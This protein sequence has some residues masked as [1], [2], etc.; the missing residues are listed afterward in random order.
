[1]SKDKRP[2]ADI[3]I[4][5]D[6]KSNPVLDFYTDYP[7]LTRMDWLVKIYKELDQDFIYAS[8]QKS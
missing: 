8:S 1:M 2:L 4:D 7:R 3:A 6:I 5:L